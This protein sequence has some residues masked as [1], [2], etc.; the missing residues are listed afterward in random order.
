MA[1]KNIGALPQVPQLM[2]DSLMVV[3]QQGQDI[4]AQLPAGDAAVGVLV[5]Q[6]LLAGGGD[7][8][9]AVR[10][11]ADGRLPDGG[12]AAGAGYEDDRPAVPGV[13]K[14]GGHGGGTGSGAVTPSKT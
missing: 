3:E 8:R 9:V 12:G 13:R 11:A 10:S 4:V 14:A 7:A 2:D 1:D 5:L 6:L